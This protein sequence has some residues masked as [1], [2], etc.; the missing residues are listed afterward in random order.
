MYIL[1][2]FII[3]IIEAFLYEYFGISLSFKSF[4]LS[5]VLFLFINLL[6]SNP[7]KNY[8]RNI[9]IFF[10]IITFLTIAN[11]LK[12]RFINSE[13]SFFDLKL[14]KAAKDTAS[15]YKES[16]P[17]N[18]IYSIIAINFIILIFSIK[19]DKFIKFLKNKFNMGNFLSFFEKFDVIF[20]N[21]FFKIFPIV[22][23]S[24][25]IVFSNFLYINYVTSSFYDFVISSKILLRN[26]NISHTNNDK[27]IHK[28]ITNAKNDPLSNV[29][30][31]DPLLSKYPYNKLDDFDIVIIQS[32]S[33][34]DISKAQEKLGKNG[35]NI[36]HDDI[37]KN[38]HYYQNNGISGDLYVPVVGGGTVNTEY[39][40]LTGYG[41]RYFVSE[42][43]PFISILKNKT[44][45]LAY[46]MKDKFKN[47]YSIA[48]HNH[49]K[50]F[51]ER[52]RVYPL[53]GIDAFIDENF[54]TEEQRN[55]LVNGWMSDKTIFD[56]TK[57]VLENNIDK[58]NFILSVTVQNHG[59]HTSKNK[60]MKNIEVKGISKSDENVVPNYVSCMEYSDEKLKEFMDYIDNRKKPAI[61]VFYGDH[62]P[63]HRYDIFRESKYYQEKNK[64]GILTNMYKTSYFIYF[65]KAINDEK[66][67]NLCGINKN[68]SSCSLHYYIRMLIGDNSKY[69]MYMYNY[70]KSFENYYDKLARDGLKTTIFRDISVFLPNNY[71]DYDSIN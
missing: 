38:F 34:F 27:K 9:Y 14:L 42:L 19:Y 52:D 37:L 54:F 10:S 67:I 53:L 22:S 49:N 2:C 59:N 71:I 24:L 61:V 30:K 68:L 31:N 7:K 35:I 50:E 56:K 20:L 46:Y 44:N 32:E 63:D 25:F 18:K 62:K 8:R 66:L 6:I 55:D 40:V 28:A 51:W 65:N 39:E 26:Y 17:N 64:K 12:V 70:I 13:I 33:F 45:S 3:S 47:S 43:N 36:Q 21:K 11:M 1:F 57:E 41:S 60:N 4:L 58:N 15:H 5:L 23:L 48:I 29:D 16:L 69:S